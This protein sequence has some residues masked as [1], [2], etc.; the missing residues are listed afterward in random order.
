M[1]WGRIFKECFKIYV[2]F[3]LEQK[4]DPYNHQV[5]I[6]GSLTNYCQCVSTRKNLT[7]IYCFVFLTA[8]SHML[9]AICK[10]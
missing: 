5:V 1:H 6:A 7:T 9:D 10:L 2:L 4:Y 3:S 8:Y